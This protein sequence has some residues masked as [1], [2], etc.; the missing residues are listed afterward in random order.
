MKFTLKSTFWYEIFYSDGSSLVF[1]FLDTVNDGRLR[2]KL[3]NGQESYDIF[4]G[5]FME[6][7][8]HGEKS[9]C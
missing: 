4:R 9:P 3:C 5:S 6:I 1:Q 7:T 8:E 2:C